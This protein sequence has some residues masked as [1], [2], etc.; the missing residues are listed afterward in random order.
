M[1]QRDFERELREIEQQIAD[2]DE[3]LERALA[4]V[5]LEVDAFRRLP[6]SDG[7][8]PAEAAGPVAAT[9]TPRGRAIPSGL[10]A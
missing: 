6:G 4:V 8:A 5:G 1:S 9:S 10:R 2:E 7:N 3:D